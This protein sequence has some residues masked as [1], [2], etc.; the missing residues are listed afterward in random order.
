MSSALT[1]SEV[2]ALRSCAASMGM[3]QSEFIREALREK[4]ER[5]GRRFGTDTRD[6]PVIC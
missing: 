4:I 5:Q 2:N 1:P 6:L 3:T